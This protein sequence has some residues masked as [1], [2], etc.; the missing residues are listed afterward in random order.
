[1]VH[2]HQPQGHWNSLHNDRR[3]R[4]VH[5]R[6]LHRL[7]EDGAHG[8][9]C[10]AYVPRRVQP[11][12]SSSRGLHPQRPSLERHDHGARHPDDVLCGHSGPVRR[13][14]QLFH[15][16]D[17]RC[18][19]HGV[20]AP[21]Q[22][23]LLDVRRRLL[24]GHRL[25][26]C[27]RRQRSGRI[28]RGLGPLRPAVDAGGWH[29]DGSCDLRCSRVRGIVD[30]RCDKHDNDIPEHAGSG[31]DASQGSAVCVV[32]LRNGVADPAVAAGSCRGDYD[33]PDRPQFRN[34][35]L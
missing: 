32:D 31:D 6:P 34:D 29:V 23:Q 24:P 11:S 20:P 16:A 9:R 15:A 28:R 12:C 17:D 35:L 30:S 22:S 13:F 10:S 18:P 27:P 21:E 5:I 4:R 8:A 2:V 7:H 33:A 3:G 26:P 19:R 14:R 1:M 25:G